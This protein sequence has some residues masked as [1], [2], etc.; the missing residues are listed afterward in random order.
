[1]R[2]LI[3][4]GLCLCVVGSAAAQT[5][6]IIRRPGEKDQVIRLDSAQTREALAKARVE[7]RK[8]TTAV[9]QRVEL[10]N[11]QITHEQGLLQK[12]QE[13]GVLLKLQ[14]QGA[15]QK[16]LLSDRMAELPAR[17]TTLAQ[18]NTELAT[19]GMIEPLIASIQERL[20]QPR[21]GIMVDTRSRDTD[22]WG[23][24]V[25]SVT[26]GGPADKAGILSGDIIMRIA[27]KSVAGNSTNGRDNDDSGPGVRLINIVSQLE[28]GKAVDVEL[29]RGT[30]NRNVK[31]TPVE[32]DSPAIARMMTDRA[33]WSGSFSYSLPSR[34][35]SGRLATPD[36]M[37]LESPSM[38]IF[39]NG[40]PGS[41]FYSW[42]SNGLFANLELVSL[43]EKLGSYFGT[44]E[45]VL[46]VSTEAR[47]S[48]QDAVVMPAMPRDVVIRTQG[49]STV[50]RAPRAGS[51][52]VRGG[53]AD[54]VYAD[55]HRTAM[56]I[57][58]EPGDVIV[59]VD[60]R[61]V[62]TPSQLM[63]VVATYDRGE[64]F[65]LQIMSLKRAETLTVLMP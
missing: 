17:I 43:N 58:V 18:K 51:Y 48:S 15:M 46:V 53:R 52:I 22:K 28:P 50:A 41:F 8:A 19:R 44:T 4:L 39:S 47:R 33:P 27:G 10:L 6:V 32:D 57:G 56:N 65:K 26:P 63:R 7:L 35:L 49:D 20:R 23:A 25:T 37:T 11:K 2:H 9:G 30:Q 59:S 14:E 34:E 1:M 62:T 13:Q 12:H 61:K 3:A 42:G 45:G 60:G 64:E 29:R 55:M 31:V 36:G 21:M 24:Y 38:S 40:T 5:E 54:T 16:Q